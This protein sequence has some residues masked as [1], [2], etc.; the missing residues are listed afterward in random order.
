[1]S[2]AVDIHLTVNGETVVE[3]VEPRLTLVDFVRETLGL[4]D[5]ARPHRAH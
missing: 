4:T 3:T 2:E 1:M 5:R